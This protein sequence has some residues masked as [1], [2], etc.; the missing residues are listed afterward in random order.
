VI[1]ESRQVASGEAT[2]VF[3]LDGT[4]LSVTETSGPGLDVRGW[5][6]EQGVSALQES[7]SATFH[8]GAMVFGVETSPPRAPTDVTVACDAERLAVGTLFDPLSVDAPRAVWLRSDGD[9][10]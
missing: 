1:I 2:A 8:P 9:G 4:V 6:L 7:S 5:Y 3:E 10:R